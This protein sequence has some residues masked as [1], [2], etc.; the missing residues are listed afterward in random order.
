MKKIAIT[1]HTS[2]LGAAL[3]EDLNKIDFEV[4]GF[5]SST[6]F[7]LSTIEGKQAVVD[8]LEQCD[9]LINNA[10]VPEGHTTNLLQKAVE[11]WRGNKE[12]MI[13]HIG[14]DI[15]NYHPDV[16]PEGMLPYHKEK[17]EQHQ[18][19][20][21]A[22]WD[23]ESVPVVNVILGALDTPAAAEHK[24]KKLDPTYVAML[25]AETLLYWPNVHVRE[26]WLMP[27]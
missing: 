7:D 17:L 25:I 18:I 15:I 24:G 4:K 20:K 9:V 14:S 11:V 13:V 16:I 12:K 5:S 10:F 22:Q 2:G 27:S 19:V 23:S 1:G 6:G 3:V 8:E 26:L 21:A